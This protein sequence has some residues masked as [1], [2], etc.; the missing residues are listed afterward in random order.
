MGIG[1]SSMN[2]SFFHSS[3]IYN[4]I[5]WKHFHSSTYDEYLLTRFNADSFSSITGF[6]YYGAMQDWSP[7][8]AA[9]RSSRSL[10]KAVGDSYFDRFDNANITV[11]WGVP[12]N[13]LEGGALV[14]G[15]LT[16][17][18]CVMASLD[19]IKVTNRRY[20]VDEVLGAVDI[21]EGF[22]GLDRSQ[23]NNPMPDSH[24]FRVEGGKIRYIRT[25]SHCV[26]S[27]CGMNGTFF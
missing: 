11:P 27:G 21:F 14:V 15:N 16:G 17:N 23:G 26:R 5:E 6:T 4:V 25:A 10:I 1:L 13:R 20:V 3:A 18:D 12:C 24:L 7:I 19:D 2:T 22:P 8:P 9:N